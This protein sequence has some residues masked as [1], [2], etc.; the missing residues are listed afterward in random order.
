V[1]GGRVGSRERRDETALGM[2]RERQG[3]ATVT[4]S[5]AMMDTASMESAVTSILA[6]GD[7]RG[8]T[9]DDIAGALGAPLNREDLQFELETLVYRGILNRRGVSYGALYTL[10][11]PAHGAR[12]LR[13]RVRSNARRAMATAPQSA[14]A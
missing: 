2:A 4:R 14:T 5:E 11:R 3:V 8:K 6:V 7:A 10:V 12:S 9:A 1:L 13:P